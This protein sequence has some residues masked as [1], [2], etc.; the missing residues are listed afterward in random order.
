MA[1][2]GPAEALAIGGHTAPIQTAPAKLPAR[3]PNHISPDDCRRRAVILSEKCDRPTLSYLADCSQ[4]GACRPGGDAAGAAWAA[5]RN[6]GTSRYA[7]CV[8]DDGLCGKAGSSACQAGA[9]YGM[10]HTLCSPAGCG[11]G[12]RRTAAV[13][14]SATYPCQARRADWPGAC[15]GDAPSA[16]GVKLLNSH[17]SSRRYT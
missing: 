11:C 9:P 13:C 4:P 8:T 14:G 5:L 1:L 10:C 3:P 15:A 17:L 6:G 12:W 16:I 2:F 7:G